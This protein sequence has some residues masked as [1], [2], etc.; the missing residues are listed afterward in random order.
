MLS[1]EFAILR[2]LK[3][4]RVNRFITNQVALFHVIIF[5]LANATVQT[6]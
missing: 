5:R 1:Y 3:N 4:G 2:P 6:N